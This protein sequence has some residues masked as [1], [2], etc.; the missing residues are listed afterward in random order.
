MQK[1]GCA[2]LKNFSGTDLSNQPY[3]IKLR[4]VF[5]QFSR[6]RQSDTHQ[7]FHRHSAQSSVKAGAFAEIYSR[8]RAAVIL[9]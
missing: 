2:S 6:V 5:F 1:R 8:V 4:A 3:F 9:P 7:V